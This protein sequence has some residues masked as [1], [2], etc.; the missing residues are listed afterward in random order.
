MKFNKTTVYEVRRILL[1]KSA[2]KVKML[3]FVLPTEKRLEVSFWT[4]F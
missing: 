2:V 4:F 1:L 3:T